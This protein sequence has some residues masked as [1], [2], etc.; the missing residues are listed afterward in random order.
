MKKTRIEALEEF[1]TQDRNDVFSRYALGLEYISQHEYERGIKYLSEV[2][3]LDPNHIAAYQQL[4]QIY[5]RLLRT[6][7][8]INIYRQGI[9]AARNLGDNHAVQEMTNEL[10]EVSEEG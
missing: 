4:G 8:S 7:E 9:E 10:E 3:K 1:F 5:A 2:L 6:D